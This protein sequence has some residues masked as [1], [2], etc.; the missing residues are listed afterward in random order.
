MSMITPEC[1]PRCGIAGGREGHYCCS[2]DPAGTGVS[3][4]IV[5]D[6]SA[7]PRD[8]AGNPVTGT[9]MCT[10]WYDGVGVMPWIRHLDACKCG[11]SAQALS[12][13]HGTHCPVYQYWARTSGYGLDRPRPERPWYGNDPGGLSPGH[14]QNPGEIADIIAATGA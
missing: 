4:V 1:T 10:R 3:A 14:G 6:A 11:V 7:G 2:Q 5:T 12:Q 9:P 13:Q 8:P